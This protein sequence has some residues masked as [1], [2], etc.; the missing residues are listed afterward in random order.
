LCNP[1]KYFN[2]IG[3]QLIIASMHWLIHFDSR[4]HPN[5]VNFLLLFVINYITKKG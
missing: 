5:T 4:I 3:N 2:F 1:E